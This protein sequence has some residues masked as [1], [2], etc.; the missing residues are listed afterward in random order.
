MRQGMDPYAYVGGN[1]ETDVDPSGNI[2]GTAGGGGDPGSQP[3]AIPGSCGTIKA[4]GGSGDGSGSGSGGTTTPTKPTPPTKPTRPSHGGSK[5]TLQKAG[6][7][8]Y[9]SVLGLCVK[10]VG[11]FAQGSAEVL[12]S[13]A[14]LIGAVVG[15]F[16]SGGLLWALAQAFQM[17]ASGVLAVI[18]N[19]INNILNSL[20]GPPSKGFKIFLDALQ[21]AA[22]LA[23]TA[24][25]IVSLWKNIEQIGKYPGKTY[26]T[27]WGG[28]WKVTQTLVAKG[29]LNATTRLAANTVG[30]FM[31]SIIGG[32]L[33]IN[34]GEQLVHDI[35]SN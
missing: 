24:I 25:T 23:S 10:D 34:D 21:F 28:F 15:L 31:N 6:G 4:G 14:V 32:D 33:L 1:P 13:I 3:C 20:S 29:T 12:G 35:V 17:F 5:K 9:T 11:K 2:R 26:S 19:G 27:S 8:G 22:D 30:N 18:K 16:Q 7:C